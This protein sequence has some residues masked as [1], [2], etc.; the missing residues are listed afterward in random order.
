[1]R[2][3]PIPGHVRHMVLLLAHAITRVTLEQADL[4]MRLDAQ[5]EEATGAGQ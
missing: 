3:D 4:Q 1:M 2:I 5:E